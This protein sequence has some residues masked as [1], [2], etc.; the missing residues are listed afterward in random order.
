[1]IGNPRYGIVGLLAMPYFLLFE[2]LSPFFAL[3]GLLV[4][5][6]LW[7]VGAVSAFYFLTFLFVSIGL[8]LL[9]TTAALAL[10]EF[11]YHRY[12]RRRDVLRLLGYALV[13]NVGYQQLHAVWRALG[14]V[15]IARGKTAWG[16]QRRRGFGTTPDEL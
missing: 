6:A 7:L 4:T 16:S 3:V 2:F 5:V 1:M 12:R 10:E 9:L 8:G 13:E 11:S 15:D 14:Y